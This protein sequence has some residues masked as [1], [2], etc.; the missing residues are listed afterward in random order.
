[1]KTRRA[2][3]ESRGAAIVGEQAAV[4][5]FAVLLKETPPAAGITPQQQALV[6]QGQIGHRDGLV[7]AVGL[8]MDGGVVRSAPLIRASAS[9]KAPCCR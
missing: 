3:A 8:A 9:G 4:E 2:T 7:V 6:D 5:Q 1:M